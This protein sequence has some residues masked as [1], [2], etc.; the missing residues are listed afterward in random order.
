MKSI[1]GKKLFEIVRISDG[2]VPY[3]YFQSRKSL[4]ETLNIL[5]RQNPEFTKTHY[6]RVLE[7]IAIDL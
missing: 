7:C 5:K 4:L 6:V 1:K 3:H 2:S